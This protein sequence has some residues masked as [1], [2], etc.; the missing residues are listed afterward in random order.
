MP[1]KSEFIDMPETQHQFLKKGMGIKFIWQES[2]CFTPIV[3]P[4]SGF[5]LASLRGKERE[6]ERKNNKYIKTKNTDSERQN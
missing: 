2:V 5:F 6:I 1:K 3:E 4:D